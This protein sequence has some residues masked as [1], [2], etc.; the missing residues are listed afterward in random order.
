MD[1][2]T[3]IA[4]ER[5]RFECPESHW[6]MEADFDLVLHVDA[7]GDTWELFSLDGIPVPSPYTVEGAFFCPVCHRAVPG[8]P[9]ARR[10]VPVPEDRGE[11]G[12]QA[13]GRRVPDVGEHRGRRVGL[14][15][16]SGRSDPAPPGAQGSGS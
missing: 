10:F 7:V 8:R 4:V 6:R 16:L 12:E 5:V 9:V 14:P 15:L 13:M 11:G 3:E 1:V 2:I